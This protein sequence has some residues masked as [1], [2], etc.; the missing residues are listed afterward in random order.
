[1]NQFAQML[2]LRRLRFTRMNAQIVVRVTVR[3]NPLWL[4]RIW[5]RSIRHIQQ[6]ISRYASVDVSSRRAKR[7]AQSGIKLRAP[8]E[9]YHL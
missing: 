1:M 5:V 2:H 6:P 8:A 3:N 4:R 9:R 7:Q